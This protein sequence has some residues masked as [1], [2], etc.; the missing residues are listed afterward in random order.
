MFLRRLLKWSAIV[1]LVLVAAGVI[2]IWPFLGVN[3]FEG[4]VE[5]LWDITSIEVDFFVRWPAARVLDEPLVEALEE[6]PGYTAL[7]DLRDELAEATRQI[8][9][10]VNPNLPFGMELDFKRDFVGREMALGGRIQTDFNSMKLDDFIF[11]TRVSWPIRFT[12]ALKRGFIRSQVQGGP[13]IE[14]VKGLYFRV[15]V[16]AR[17]ANAMRGFRTITGRPGGDNVF[18]LARVGDV[19]LF[20]DN[21]HW[22]EHAL[23]GGVATLPADAWFESEF[24][25]ASQRH[26]NRGFE[27]F[28]RPSLTMR[29][30]DAR[31]RSGVDSP[32]KFLT[33]FLPT[34]VLGEVTLQA[35]PAGADGLSVSLSAALTTDGFKHLPLHLQELYD[36]EK[37]D[38][39]FELGEEG[40]G[41]FIP[42]DRTVAAL[43]LRA[44]P[45]E[46][47]Q[48]IVNLIPVDEKRLLDDQVRSVPRSRFT[49]FERLLKNLMSDLGDTHLL[50]LHRPPIF[51]D[52]D[53]SAFQDQEFPPTPSGEFA[54]SLISSVK[55]SVAPDQVR[56]KMFRSLQ[57]LGMNSA[58]THE[59]GKFHLARLIT[60]P[61]GFALIKPAYGAMSGGK[62]FVALSSSV[63]AM[64]A[65]FAAGE[66]PEQRYVTQ[67]GVASVVGRL[68]GSASFALLVDGKTLRKALG[69][70]VRE[71]ARMKMDLAFQK[72][73]WFEEYQKA[74]MTDEQA[75]QE[76]ILRED[77]FI[78]DRYPELK[79]E[80]EEALQWLRSIDL[81]VFSATLGAGPEKKV[82]AQGYARFVPRGR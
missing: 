44:R 66:D 28:L 5:H 63:D 60:E 11:M 18:Y 71:Y 57:Y 80:Y 3:P 46:L 33:A 52:A 79:E 53:Y 8:A 72:K 37:G 75:V 23:Q 49:S 17:A 43:V 2:A 81:A 67:Q 13:E 62:R 39:R 12:S 50:V 6:E 27:A 30:L 77:R 65:V 31:T 19:L 36:S 45:E 69:D 38:V 14:V 29:F 61:A 7:R 64:E 70:R 40:I 41:R 55:Q 24:M 21:D 9:E 34:R 73:A 76:I 32:L 59:S 48:L 56:E 47:V 20:S 68:S 22:I 51:D 54:F 4:P 74:G 58:G 42:R 78:A 1:L 35:R 15:T 26:N 10:Q 16:D 25:G 82:Q